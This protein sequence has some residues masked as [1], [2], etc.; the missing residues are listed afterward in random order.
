MY[1]DTFKYLRGQCTACIYQFGFIITHKYCRDNCMETTVFKSQ[2]FQK[3]SWLLTVLLL[4]KILQRRQQST[5]SKMH[6]DINPLSM[7]I[8]IYL[9]QDTD[10]IIPG[11]ECIQLHS[12]LMAS[13]F[14]SHGKC[15]VIITMSV[16]TKPS[17]HCVTPGDLVL[18]FGQVQAS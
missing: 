13:C 3:M 8:Q 12:L 15:R 7:S 16:T 1:I 18:Y 5:P 14:K 10:L 9:V 4:P 17:W 6:C 2:L 11:I